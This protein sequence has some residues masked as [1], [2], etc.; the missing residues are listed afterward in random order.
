VN[1]KSKTLAVFPCRKD[2]PPRIPKERR[3]VQDLFSREQEEAD[4]RQ[5]DQVQTT[6]FGHLAESPENR[7]SRRIRQVLEDGHPTCA[8]FSSGKD[9]SV[10]VSILLNVARQMVESGA[11]CPPIVI[12]HSDTLVEQPEVAELAHAEIKKMKAYAAKHG[13]PLE[14][15]IGVPTL[16]DSF[17]VRVLGGRA[18]PAFPS[19]RADC[20]IDWKV[21]VNRKLLDRVLARMNNTG[22]WKEPVVMTGVRNDESIARDQRIKKRGEVAEGIWTNENGDLRLS[23]LL[24]FTLDDVWE[25]IGLVNSGAIESYTDFA[26]V[27]RIYRAAGNSSCVIVA[28]MKSQA[29]TKP[30]GVRTGCWVC[31]RVGEDRSMSQMI[32]SDPRRYGHLKPLANLRDFISRTQFDWSKRT[33]V[34]RSIDADGCITIGADTYSPQMLK[35]LLYYTLS[36]EVASGVPIVSTQQLIAVDARWSQYGIAPPFSALKI[37]FDVQEGNLRH[38]PEVSR[39][40]KTD[41]PRIGKLQVGS[42]SY[43][44]AMR[45]HVSGLRNVGAEL[46]HESCGYELKSLKDGALVIDVEGED[47]FEVDAQGAED[48]LYFEA[49]RM[50]DQYC[51]DDCPDWTWGYRTYLQ[52]GTIT[53]SKGRSWQVHEI[54]QRAQWRQEH[55]LHGQRSRQELEARCTVLFSNQMELV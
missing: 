30:C 44:R 38:A 9:S 13:I 23:P 19:T 34:G 48:F 6:M 1:Q 46:F 53:L 21:K 45:G 7:A 43:D 15:H 27:M 4:A 31:T 51:R 50:I 39:Y 41:V 55:E 17:V 52:W 22:Q 42:S 18:L 29:H 12:L 32:Q 2:G 35:D 11:Q 26:E 54:L 16:A 24:C 37:Y 8:G 40:P 28:D 10:L 33:F 14:A 25:Y 36:A 3:M 5:D 20:S 47:D 49:Q